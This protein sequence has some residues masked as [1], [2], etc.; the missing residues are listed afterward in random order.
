[1]TQNIELVLKGFLS[2]S[3]TEKNEFIRELNL[4][5]SAGKTEK[6]CQ[7]ILKSKQASVVLG[8]TGSVCPCCGK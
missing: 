4:W 7:L 2:L 6:E 5:L 8:P 3:R 1:M